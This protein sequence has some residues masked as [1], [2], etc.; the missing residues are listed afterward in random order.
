MSST[1]SLEEMTYCT[2]THAHKR[3]I[4]NP[5]RTSNLG[6]FLRIDQLIF[7]FSTFGGGSQTM[8]W[9]KES[10]RNQ[11]SK[12]LLLFFNIVNIH[13]P[14]FCQLLAPAMWPTGAQ[15]TTGYHG[16]PSADGSLFR[17]AIHP[18]VAD[19]VRKACHCPTPW[20]WQKK[21]PELAMKIGKT[22]MAT[23]WKL[24][25]PIEIWCLL[26]SYSG[27]LTCWPWK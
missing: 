5:G 4:T 15:Q 26:I 18:I 20:N 14:K 8:L 17:H 6:L 27:K 24:G 9:P 3:T 21:P 11:T 23:S 1:C 12:P 7:P 25:N 22:W 19:P 10:F 13:K 2:H 16:G